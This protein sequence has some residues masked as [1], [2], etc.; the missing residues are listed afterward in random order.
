MMNNKHLLKRGIQFSIFLL[1]AYFIVKYFAGHREDLAL[2]KSIQAGHIFTLAGILLAINLIAGYKLLLVLRSLDLKGVHFYSWLKI[3]IISRFI[4]FHI[5]QGA[6]LYRIVKLKQS[7]GFPYTKT[8]SMTVF[9]S[10]L[11]IILNLTFS[12]IIIYFLQRQLNPEYTSALNIILLSIGILLISP[13]ILKNI[14][15]LFPAPLQALTWIK[16]KLG[17]LTSNLSRQMHNLR[18]L[19]QY[20]ALTIVMFILFIAAI[21]ISFYS[22]DI[23]LNLIQTTLFTLILLLTRLINLTPGNIGL[24]EVVCGYFSQYLGATMGSGVIVS[25]IIR[26]IEYLFLGIL[27]LIFNRTFLTGKSEQERSE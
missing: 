23:R 2:I 6:N 26:I 11:E 15:K 9:F 7:F 27:T 13:V 19:A 25:G 21:Y 12:Y 16:S 10:W 22:I 14:L 1:S 17:D 24:T 20:T 5:S 4:N 18:L 8:I 3:F